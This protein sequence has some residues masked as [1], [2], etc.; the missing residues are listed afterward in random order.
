MIEDEKVFL[1]HSI[2]ANKGQYK[3]NCCNNLFV[4]YGKFNN[5]ESVVVIKFIQVPG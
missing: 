1:P 4:P 5:K 2:R 3:C